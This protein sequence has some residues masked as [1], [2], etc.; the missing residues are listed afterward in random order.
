MSFAIGSV[1]PMMVGGPLPELIMK[2][3]GTPLSLMDIIAHTMTEKYVE[4]HIPVFSSK[5]WGHFTLI[6]NDLCVFGGR[7]ITCDRCPATTPLQTRSNR[8]KDGSGRRRVTIACRSCGFATKYKLPGN[9]TGGIPIADGDKDYISRV[10]GTKL[11]RTPYPLLPALV[12]WAQKQPETTTAQ[13]SKQPGGRRRR[14]PDAPA[15][16]LPVE[17]RASKR[18]RQSSDATSPPMGSQGAK[19]IG[20]YTVRRKRSK[21]CKL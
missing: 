15:V 10:A 20:T 9:G 12:T 17:R 8:M 14:Q 5:E 6:K 4:A 3:V 16:Q 18:G 13:G 11:I 1:V 7:K 2:W 21:I 19:Q